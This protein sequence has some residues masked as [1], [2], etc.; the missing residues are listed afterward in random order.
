MNTFVILIIFT[1]QGRSTRCGPCSSSTLVLQMMSTVEA[2]LF[3]RVPAEDLQLLL[4]GCCQQGS[5]LGPFFKWGGALRA[6]F[7]NAESYSEA[8][9]K[10]GAVS[11]RLM[12]ACLRNKTTASLKV[13]PTPLCWG[14]LAWG[15]VCWGKRGGVG[16]GH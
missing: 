12:T 11:R 1:T 16:E 15:C 9:G 13:I 4:V 8:S 7:A 10:W 3:A 5:N 6:A 14:A 2:A